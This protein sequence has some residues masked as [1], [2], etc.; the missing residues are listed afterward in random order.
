MLLEQQINPNI[1]LY[2]VLITLCQIYIGLFWSKFSQVIRRHVEFNADENEAVRD[3][4]SLHWHVGPRSR[5]IHNSTF[6]T[7][8]YIYSEERFVIKQQ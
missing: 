4:Q 8:I 2:T 3:R 5:N 7:V 6:K 1:I